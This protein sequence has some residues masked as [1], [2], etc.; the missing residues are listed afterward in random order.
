[1]FFQLS[2]SVWKDCIYLDDR[3]VQI[4][5]R[6]REKK[7]ASK[8][9]R[10]PVTQLPGFGRMGSVSFPPLSPTSWLMLSVGDAGGP[11]RGV[12]VQRQDKENAVTPDWREMGLPGVFIWLDLQ[13][14]AGREVERAIRNQVMPRKEIIIRWAIL[15]S[16]SRN[17]DLQTSTVNELVFHTHSEGGKKTTT[18]QLFN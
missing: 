16:A 7:A 11:R 3:K 18:K 4:Y 9:G 14:G 10:L 2:S 1:M 8:F 15:C 6:R 13:I 17:D 5:L 12:W